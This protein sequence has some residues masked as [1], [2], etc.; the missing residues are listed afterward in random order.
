[1]TASLGRGFL[2]ITKRLGGGDVARPLIR[3]GLSVG[4]GD[5]VDIAAKVSMPKRFAEMP[6]VV[7][8]VCKRND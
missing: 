8:V 1:M 6:I 4:T 7:H 3:A 2:I 5:I